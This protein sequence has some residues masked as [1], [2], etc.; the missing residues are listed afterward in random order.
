MGSLAQELFDVIIDQVPL[1]DTRSCSLV[2]KRWRERSQKRHFSSITFARE[3]EV[4]R[5]YT[6]IPQDPNGIPSY[7][8]DVTFR[9]FRWWRDPTLFSRVLKCF[10]RVKTL[11]IS[12][13]GVIHDEL[14]NVVSHGEFRTQLT[15]LILVYP[16]CALP[17]LMLF[18]LSFP[19]L[20][21]LVV[22]GMT[23]MGPSLVPVPAPPDTVCRTGPLESLKLS[24]LRSEVICSIA[25]C[26]ITS[27]RIDL[28]VGYEMTENILANSSE[29]AAELVLQGTGSLCNFSVGTRFTSSPDIRTPV[30]HSYAFFPANPFLSFP[31]LT[32]IEVK[33]HSG[34]L[35]APLANLLP[36]IRSA[37][38]LS[39]IT[40]E[41]P[42]STRAVEDVLSLLWVDVDKWLAWLA[43]G[44]K[45]EGGLGV[46]LTPWPE[47][48]SSVEGCLPEFRKAGGDLRVDAGIRS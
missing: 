24:W 23:K 33:V 41:Y 30:R 11:V 35:S 47:E 16:L 40:F 46:V 14:S 25:R 37:P 26:G 39:S 1:Q 43:T 48:K 15:F 7:A 34:F 9:D 12:K 19:N 21:E 10:S 27:R 22:S 2:A 6:D 38:A 17:T 29:M 31:A 8:N 44:A 5:W 4:A 45:S 36:R 3:C 13:T 20:R 32:T 18:I 42:E 28:D